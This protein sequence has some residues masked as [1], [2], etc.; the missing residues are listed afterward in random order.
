MKTKSPKTTTDSGL[1][2]DFKKQSKNTDV[3]AITIIIFDIYFVGFI[4][5]YLIGRF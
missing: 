5:G 1:L 2:N 3:L 4:V